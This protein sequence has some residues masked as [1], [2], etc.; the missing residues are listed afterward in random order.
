M[1]LPSVE[2][3]Y[4]SNVGMFGS[5]PSPLVHD[6]DAVAGEE[7][8]ATGHSPA[9]VSAW[10]LERY[11]QNVTESESCTPAAAQLESGTRFPLTG[12]SGIGGFGVVAGGATGSG[13][14]AGPGVG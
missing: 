10:S 14:T 11:G 12:F 6:D 13:Q 5:N 3:K 4:A 9:A 1:P 2:L 8:S 7:V